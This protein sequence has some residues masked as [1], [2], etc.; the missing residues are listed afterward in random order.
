VI[1]EKDG[2]EDLPHVPFDIVREHA[3]QH[4]STNALGAAMMDRPDNYR[5]GRP[6]WR[7]LVARQVDRCLRKRC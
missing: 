7:E 3:Q 5:L 4:V 2:L 6:G 1:V